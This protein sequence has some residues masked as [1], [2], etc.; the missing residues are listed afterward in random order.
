[1]IKFK[2]IRKRMN[3]LKLIK[4]M[5]IELYNKRMNLLKLIKIMQIKKEKR[6]E[7]KLFVFF[8]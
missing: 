2:E 5:Q 1:M 3:L 8:L 6:K 7:E 4:I